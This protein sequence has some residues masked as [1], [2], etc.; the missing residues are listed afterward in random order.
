MTETG[1]PERVDKITKDHNNHKHIMT[2]VYPN[3]KVASMK[4]SWRKKLEENATW[5]EGFDERFKTAIETGF[6]MI[7][8]E[9]DAA[10]EQ[11]KLESEKND[12]AL[13]KEY[14]ENHLKFIEERKQFVEDKEKRKE[15]LEKEIRSQMEGY[16]KKVFDDS[17]MKS[18]ALKMWNNVG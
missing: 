10:K 3:N 15:E 16:K 2:V 7:D 13:F 8:D 4:A 6:S 1:L 12:E 18:Q 9:A 17:K 5:L 11:I 14:K